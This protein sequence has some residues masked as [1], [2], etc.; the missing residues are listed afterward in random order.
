MKSNLQY[1]AEDRDGT[2][3]L[4]KEFNDP[5][6][7]YGWNMKEKQHQVWYKP[8]NSAPYMVCFAKNPAHAVQQMAARVRADKMRAVDLLAEI[9]EHNERLMVSRQNDAMAEV[10]SQLRAVASG[11]QYFLTG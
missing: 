10:H 3:R 11:R 5:R 8:A 6:I 9:D 1:L 2:K 7:V 4:R